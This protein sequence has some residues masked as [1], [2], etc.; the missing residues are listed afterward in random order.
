MNVV[1]PNTLVTDVLKELKYDYSKNI[2]SG[3]AI[4]QNDSE[5]VVGII[6]DA[7]FRR[8]ISK[9]TN[10][11]KLKIKNI[12]KK[13]FIFIFSDEFHKKDFKR[14]ELE[15]HDKSI[16][17]LSS[18]VAV[19]ILDRQRKFKSSI[20]IKE[21]SELIYKS[22]REIVIIGLGFVGLTLALSI[23]EKNTKVFG[24]DTDINL[25]KQL[26]NYKSPIF[27]P[28]IEQILKNSMDK[29]LFINR[30]ITPRSNETFQAR[31]YVICVGTPII[32]GKLETSQLSLAI[33]KISKELM[34]GDC[35]IFRSTVPVG[36]TRSAAKKIESLTKLRAG[37]DFYIGFAPE[38]TLEGNAIQECSQIP[39]IYCGLTDSYSNEIAKTFSALS[40]IMI[41]MESLEACE[42]GK[43]ITNSYRD[44]VFGFSNEIALIAENYNL[45]INKL[46]GHVNSGYP[47][48]QIKKPSPGVG[49]PCLSKDSYILNINSNIETSVIMSARQ[50][51]EITPVKIVNK[52]Y[53]FCEAK[54]LSNILIIGLAFKGSPE[55]NDIRNSTGAEISS[56][57]SG[58]GLDIR[59]IDNIVG[60]EKIQGLNFKIFSK[61]EKWYPEIIC[62]LNDHSE[63]LNVFTEVVGM[64][65]LGQINLLFDPWYLLVSLYDDTRIKEIWTMSKRLVN[66]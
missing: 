64:P 21:F 61:S 66:E 29:T 54:H 15:I 42:M 18:L 17:N 12:M 52:I 1:S 28:G 44:V 24:I 20:N 58:Y 46:I 23:T 16:K 50:I 39:Q 35:V 2:P 27:E 25:I 19:P 8:N 60:N 43:L 53:S 62:V 30:T 37:I 13:D 6:T 32:N 38:R 36:Y 14:I 48:N 55:T 45:D 10:L 22:E 5:E 34:V 51:N 41:K 4:V 49:G 40:E 31:S 65:N 57:L 63:N 7:D 33:S 11:K 3:F 56:K 59:I 47:R 26:K 9:S